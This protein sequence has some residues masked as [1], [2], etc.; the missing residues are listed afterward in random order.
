MM[1]FINTEVFVYKS[2]K[3]KIS[4]VL[5]GKYWD[6]ELYE[7]TYVNISSLSEH[8]QLMIFTNLEIIYLNHTDNFSTKLLPQHSVKTSTATK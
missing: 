6:S 8:R 7:T 5:L 3:T 2:I 1:L 4:H